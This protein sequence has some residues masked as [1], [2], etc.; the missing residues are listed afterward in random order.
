MTACTRD[1]ERTNMTASYSSENVTLTSDDGTEDDVADPGNVIGRLGG[2]V[3]LLMAI[4]GAVGNF[5]VLAAVIKCRT[6]HRSYN[7]FI[8]SLSVTDLMFNLTVMPF[9]ADTYFRRKWIYSSVLC[10]WH[11]YFGTTVIIS[12]AFHIAVIAS[13]RYHVIVR[14]RFYA[15]WMSSGRA[16]V[17]QLI[18]IWI[19]S[20]AIVLPGVV[21]LLPVRIGY[22]DQ[23]SRCNYVRAQSKEALGLVFGAG[24]IIPCGVMCY[25]YVMI[26]RRARQSR[27]RM[28]CYG[29][30]T[31]GTPASG[32]LLRHSTPCRT[33]TT[34]STRA[35]GLADPHS[36]PVTHSTTATAVGV[37]E[38]AP[39][40][41]CW[42]ADSD[43]GVR[44]VAAPLDVASE[45]ATVIQHLNVFHCPT[46]TAVNIVISREASSSYCT[47]GKA[48]TREIS[49]IADDR[50]LADEVAPFISIPT[51]VVQNGLLP[52]FVLLSD[53]STHPE[54][55]ADSCPHGNASVP[56]TSGSFSAA[57]AADAVART[58]ACDRHTDEDTGDETT[59]NTAADVVCSSAL[60]S[61][62]C[63][64]VAE[65]LPVVL[66]P[67]DGALEVASAVPGRCALQVPP[68]G[69][70][71][72]DIE[73][74][75]PSALSAVI[76]R[77]RLSSIAGED[78]YWG[79]P[80]PVSS[81]SQ[82][83]MCGVD[84]K[85]S[86]TSTTT[87]AHSRSHSLRMIMAVFLA[88]IVTYLPFSLTNL[89]DEHSA[90]NRNVY[91]ITSLGFWAGSC[92]NPLIYGIMNRQFR[93]AYRSV[94]FACVR[95]PL[96][97]ITLPR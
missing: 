46:I 13:S 38:K 10:Q 55:N 8:A 60:P 44:E 70:A 49:A 17:L 65:P 43:E 94:L 41:S 76:R 18:A 35:A 40:R 11:T 5:L 84:S 30:S 33:A 78:S 31:T 26:W 4:G 93:V 91:M 25:F 89:L 9:Y 23:L 69:I 47:S 87:H 68:L 53:V 74:R 81:V 79:C 7:T 85:R 80:V 1:A 48:T 57:A 96:S 82:L 51:A 75:R 73:K 3:V 62:D 67:G 64:P 34:C 21:G 45:A 88:Y 2:T 22:S 39:P 56:C 59:D 20:A 37:G 32:R 29:S 36:P 95:R 97:H 12:S 83:A 6:L 61:T 86:I 77:L 28:N 27:H 71:A 50:T 14:P 72:A 24:F 63:S 58:A 66:T 54:F 16:V 52:S 42:T 19:T 92:V 90:L 15:R